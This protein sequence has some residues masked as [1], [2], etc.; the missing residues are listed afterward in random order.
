MRNYPRHKAIDE[1]LTD[2]QRARVVRAFRSGLS[3]KEIKEVW[4][5]GDA[6]LNRALDE[7]TYQKPNGANP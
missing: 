2:P 5:I 4:G 3:K 1:G 7:A 6:T